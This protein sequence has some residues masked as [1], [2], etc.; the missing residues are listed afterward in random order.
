MNKPF[1]GI[2][3]CKVG[4]FC[5]GLN[6]AN[7]HKYFVAGDIGEIYKCL[8]EAKI[9]LI[10]VPI[11]LSEDCHGRQCDKKA[12]KF[13]G[14]RA[15]SVFP[16]PCR[17]AIHA[18]R[19]ENGSKKDKIKAGKIASIKIT[20]GSLSEQ[21]W[22][23]VPKIDEVAQFLCENEDARKLFREVHPEVC[24]CAL[25]NNTSLQYGK[26]KAGGFKERIAIL[27]KSLPNVHQIFDDVRRNYLKTKVGDDDIHDALV[28]ALTAKIGYKKYK[29][30][31]D[32]PAKDSCGLPMGMVYVVP[33][34][35]S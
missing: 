29:T 25:N 16:V 9:A 33:P 21:T 35:K 34:S 28:A 10:D 23:I 7:E 12:R 3:G 15:S 2:D 5:I 14:G 6:A 22:G 31:P 1:W 11:G 20:G 19:N 24:F 30:L 13:V 27:E 4:W 8:Q 26:K 32:K 18:Y 17:Q